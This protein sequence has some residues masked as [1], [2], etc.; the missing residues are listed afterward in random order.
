M[1]LKKEL[2]ENKK[3]LLVTISKD[4][5][6]ILNYDD[7]VIE[8]LRGND[9]KGQVTL[10]IKAPK[11]IGITGSHIIQKLIWERTKLE[12]ERDQLKKENEFLINQRI[13]ER[14]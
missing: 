1:N 6:T 5:P 11:E 13:K 12:E 9:F 4:V 3:G 14:E 8:I 10:H 2:A 7:H